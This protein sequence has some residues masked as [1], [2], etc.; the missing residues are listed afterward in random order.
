MEGETDA[1]DLLAVVEARG[2]RLIDADMDTLLDTWA[3]RDDDTW[4][5]GEAGGTQNIKSVASK[6]G[7]YTHPYEAPCKEH[8]GPFT[9]SHPGKRALQI[10]SAFAWMNAH[11]GWLAH[12]VPTDIVDTEYPVT[13]VSKVKTPTSRSIYFSMRYK[14]EV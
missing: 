6:L 13:D 8:A 7:E 9:I 1:S 4:A 5:E 11:V 2:D 3:D 10:A 12:D 14:R